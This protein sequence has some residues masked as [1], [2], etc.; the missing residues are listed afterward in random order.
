[1][2][3]EIIKNLERILSSTELRKVENHQCHLGVFKEP[4]LSYMLEGKK[5]IESRFSKQKR[6]PYKRIKKG[7]IVFIKRS[8]GP[9]IGYFIV[10]DVLFFNLYEISI[11]E[12]KKKYANS[13]CVNE[14]FWKEK[15][16]SHYATLLFISKLIS[17]EPFKI[18]KRGMQTW[19][20]LD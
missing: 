8:S 17:F 4:Y 2:K 19:I 20:E 16:N 6:S 13:L 3:E 15:K 12:L 5:T 10:K 11:D 18:N 7:D 9:V 14:E 1:M